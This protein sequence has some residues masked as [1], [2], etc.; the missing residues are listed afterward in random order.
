MKHVQVSACFK[1]IFKENV[2]FSNSA[3]VLL[4]DDGVT[5]LQY[6]GNMLVQYAIK[7]PLACCLRGLFVHDIP[8]I[9]IV[10]TTFVTV[11]YT[12]LYFI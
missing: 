8:S 4:K 3:L 6:A 5:L 2:I 1:R 9:S 11:S 12:V 7:E 10:N